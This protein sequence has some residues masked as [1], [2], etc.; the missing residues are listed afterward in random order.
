MPEHISESVAVWR[1]YF[2][3]QVC[4]KKT[5]AHVVRRLRGE[6]GKSLPCP[7]AQRRPK[8]IC[9]TSKKAKQLFDLFLCRPPACG[10]PHNGMLFIKG[11][12]DL[13]GDLFLKIFQFPV[14]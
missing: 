10:K 9:A 4:K 7:I 14:L 2:Y 6:L 11:L 5:A 8:E 1:Y 3:A 13:K 12:P